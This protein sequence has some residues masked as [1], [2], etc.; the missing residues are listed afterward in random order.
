RAGEAAGPVK[1]IAAFVEKPEAAAAEALVREGALWNSGVFIGAA[2]TLTAEFAALATEV[3]GAATRALAA[4]SRDGDTLP[5]GPAFAEAPA[6]AFDRAVMEKTAKGAVLAVD[7]AWSDLGAWD[8]VAAASGQSTLVR[9]APGLQVSL[10]G[11]AD[12]AVV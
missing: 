9:A 11:V 10:V 7:F 3:A 12:V 4:A 5:L 1:P 2:A 6:I 8:A